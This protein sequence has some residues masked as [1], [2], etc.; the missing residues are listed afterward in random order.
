MSLKVLLVDSDWYFLTQVTSI[1]ESRGH[2]VVREGNPAEALD[3]ARRWRPDVVMVDVQLPEVHRGELVADL[4]AIQ[5]RPAIVL[6]S[7]MEHFERAWAAWQRGGDDVLFKPILH[8]SDVHLA[9]LTAR[10]NA[11]CP[12]HRPAA[13]PQP[14]A[15]SA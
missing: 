14:T 4:A 7:A 13:Q 15:K 11:L 6:L 10:K 12:E 5:P 8:P 2:H 9:I 1:L 3:R